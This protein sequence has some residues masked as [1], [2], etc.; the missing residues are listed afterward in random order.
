M[1][2][3]RF[4]ARSSEWIGDMTVWLRD[5]A[6]DNS[7]QLERLRRGLR[8]GREQELTPRQREMVFLYYDRGLKMSQI[9]QKLGVN[10]STVSRTVKRAKQRLY[11]CLRY[12]L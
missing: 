9:A 10:R 4:D 6:E 3:T 12:A 2:D 1:R 5:H 8:R 11:R 7:E